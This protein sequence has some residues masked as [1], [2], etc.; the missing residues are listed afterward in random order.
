MPT[1]QHFVLCQWG[2]Y[3]HE[4]V[5]LS[6]T[7]R[8]GGKNSHDSWYRLSSRRI[9]M[10]NAGMG[11]GTEYQACIQ[12][13][14]NSLIASVAGTSGH[15]VRSVLAG[16][17]H[18]NKSRRRVLLCSLHHRKKSSF[19]QP[20]SRI[21][22]ELRTN[23]SVSLCLN[24][25]TFWLMEHTYAMCIMPQRRSNTIHWCCLISSSISLLK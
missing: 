3:A 25:P 6:H 13:P 7:E 4:R 11:V 19:M 17:R 8:C 23:R 14:Y 15:F 5:R 2:F 1:P 24:E 12:H 9:D 20:V 18:A 10:Q 21:M 22:V 16:K